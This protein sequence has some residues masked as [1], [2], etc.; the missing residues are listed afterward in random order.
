MMNVPPPPQVL[1]RPG[2]IRWAVGLP[3]GPRS[4][5]WSVVGHSGGDDVFIG[6]RNR[7]S[8][9]KLSLHPAKWRL[10]YTEQAAGQYV[11]DGVDR[12]LTRWERTA[13]TVSGWRRAAT[14]VIAPSNLGPG[15]PERRVKGGG[16]VAFYPATNAGWGLR[17]TCS[18]VRRIAVA[19]RSRR[20]R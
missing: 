8:E 4:H 9:I 16:A 20:Q 18:S 12:V 15:Y 19:L 17:L 3:V 7:M 11:P 13:E 6:L 2:V 5:T 10:A 14:I 1:N